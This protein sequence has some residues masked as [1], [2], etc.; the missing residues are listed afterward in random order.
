MDIHEF[1]EQAEVVGYGGVVHGTNLREIGER[2]EERGERRE[3]RGERRE[4]REELL[5]MIVITTAG[6]DKKKVLRTSKDFLFL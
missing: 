6:R 4:E 1:G 2:R 3:E 5:S